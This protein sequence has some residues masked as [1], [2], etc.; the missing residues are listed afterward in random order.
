MVV[1]FFL[2]AFLL[3]RSSWICDVSIRSMPKK[4]PQTDEEAEEPPQPDAVANASTLLDT[5]SSIPLPGHMEPTPSFGVR[6]NTTRWSGKTYL[7]NGE[8]SLHQTELHP[9]PMQVSPYVSPRRE[10][11]TVVGGASP[12]SQSKSEISQEISFR[13][14]RPTAFS[15]EAAEKVFSDTRLLMKPLLSE[16]LKVGSL[17]TYS[18]LELVGFRFSSC[19]FRRSAWLCTFI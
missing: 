10:L 19:S 2:V 1:Y 6:A 12:S 9:Q 7:D 11:P 17:C 14:D 18:T 5:E 8:T 15:I 13:K 16:A 4:K 3:M